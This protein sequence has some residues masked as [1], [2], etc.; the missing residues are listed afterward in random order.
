LLNAGALPVPLEIAE[1][2]TVSPTLGRDSV[3]RSLLAGVVGFVAVVLFMIFNYRLPGLLAD[4]A[5]VMYVVLVLAVLV[6]SKATLTLPGLAGFLISIGMAVDANVLILE[7]FK[8][9][10]W[11]GKGFR[12]AIEAGFHRAWTAI[13]D[14]NLTTLIACAVLYFLGTS[15]IKSFA[16]T[17][18]VGVV[19][20]MFTAVVVSRW[21]L[22]CFPGAGTRL[23]WFVPGGAPAAVQS[24]PPAAGG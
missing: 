18:F 9:E 21:L 8:E 15:A 22:D 17:L 2:R 7:R 16:I 1:N 3:Y 20:S 23:S 12:A 14:S 10:L 19:C 13:L 24:T 4:L 6:V 11:G 5:L